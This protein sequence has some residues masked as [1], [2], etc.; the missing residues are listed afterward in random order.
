MVEN[1]GSVYV[2]CLGVS[3]NFVCSVICQI[4]ATKC[5]IMIFSPKKILRTWLSLK[6]KVSSLSHVYPSFKVKVL[7]KFQYV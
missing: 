6:L 5:F 1:F 2:L 4:F 3:D 7:K